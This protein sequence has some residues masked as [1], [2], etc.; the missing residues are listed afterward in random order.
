MPSLVLPWWSQEVE[1]RRNRQMLH[2]TKQEDQLQWALMLMRKRMNILVDYVSY[3]IGSLK[4]LTYLWCWEYPKVPDLSELHCNCDMGMLIVTWRLL[5]TMQEKKHDCTYHL[6]TSLDFI[7]YLVASSGLCLQL[8]GKVWDKFLLKAQFKRNQ[9]PRSTG[10]WRV[11][12][13]FKSWISTADKFCPSNMFVIVFWVK[14]KIIHL[15]ISLLF[16][17]IKGSLC[18]AGFFTS[19]NTRGSVQFIF[20]MFLLHCRILFYYLIFYEQYPHGCGKY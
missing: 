18:H 8:M 16:N 9:N 17:T 12:Q 4:Y 19:I 10:I 15:A 5:G 3:C 2:K 14:H 1:L 20:N 6:E 13:I 11:V 7:S